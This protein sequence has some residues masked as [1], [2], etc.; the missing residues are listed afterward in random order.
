MGGR[1]WVVGVM[2]VM[3]VAGGCRVFGGVV[4]GGGRRC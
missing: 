2:G 4:L 3:G 1:G